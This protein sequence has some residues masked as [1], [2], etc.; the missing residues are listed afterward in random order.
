MFRNCNQTQK[1]FWLI[2]KHPKY[3]MQARMCRRARPVFML[4]QGR[5]ELF[6]KR[7]EGCNKVG[8][9]A[10]FEISSNCFR[11]SNIVERYLMGFKTNYL[12]AQGVRRGW[13]GQNP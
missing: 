7:N 4:A 2:P 9:E 5:A 11:K 8:R 12:V 10:W 3:N 13:Q 6:K 1:G